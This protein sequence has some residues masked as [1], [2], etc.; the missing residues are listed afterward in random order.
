MTAAFVALGGAV[1]AVLR[2]AADLWLRKHSHLPLGTLVVNIVGSALLGVLTGVALDEPTF[3]ALGA[4]LCGSLTTY[5]TFSYDAVQL[6]AEG[7][8]PT[9]LLYVGLTVVAG[10]AAAAGGLLAAQ[11]L[12]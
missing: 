12:V 8:R 4:G 10:V 1:G 3:A 9:S 6:L 11:L 7:R 5:S 2:Y